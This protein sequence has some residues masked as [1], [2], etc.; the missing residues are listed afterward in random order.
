MLLNL[1]KKK[2][3]KNRE[4]IELKY[5]LTLLLRI[6]ENNLKSQS[7]QRFALQSIEKGCL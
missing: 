5:M 4:D 2:T 3:S 1:S 6:S 7:Y